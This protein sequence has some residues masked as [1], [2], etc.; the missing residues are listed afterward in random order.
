MKKIALFAFN[1]DSMCFVHVLLN[2]LDFQDKGYEVKI[3]LEGSTT[4]LIPNLANKENPL[5]P[6]YGK[7]RALGL[8]E[9]ACRACSKKMGTLDAVRAEGMPLL[10][11]IGGHPSLARYREEGFEVI[12]F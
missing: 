5:H 3:I 8:F 4:K 10:D 12:T 1:G 7:A 9:G 2:A 6:L 11:E